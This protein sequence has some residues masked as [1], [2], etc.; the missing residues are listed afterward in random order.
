MSSSK[1]EELEFKIS[2]LQDLVIRLALQSPDLKSFSLEALKQNLSAEE[3][4]IFNDELRQVDARESI[5]AKDFADRLSNKFSRVIDEQAV[6]N[7]LEGYRAD[8][9]FE[10]KVNSILSP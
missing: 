10:P 5:S 3:V 8:G 2:L 1:V 9:I 4:N 6:I 7:L